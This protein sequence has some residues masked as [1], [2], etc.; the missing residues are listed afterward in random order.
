MKKISLPALII[1][2]LIF[3][4]IPVVQAQSPQQTL[5]QLISDLQK[6]PNNNDLREK[7]I[8]HVQTM[9]PAPAITE[10]AHQ[11]FVIAQTFQKKAKNAKGYE[12]AINEY[13][14]ALLIAP[15]WSEAY[16]NMGITLEQVGRYD[17]AISALKLYIATNPPDAR[18]AQDKIYEIEATKKLA[19]EDRAAEEAKEQ[20][21]RDAER[22]KQELYGWI[23]GSW[24][25]EVIFP[26]NKFQMRKECSREGNIIECKGGGYGTLRAKISDAG[27]QQWQF[28]SLQGW[29]DTS[30]SISADRRQ[31]TFPYNDATC[32][33]TKE[34]W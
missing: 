8:K 3:A 17:E 16:N 7:I 9:K 25:W 10:E 11:H 30:V 21:K 28:E 22:R 15:W 18:T 19:Q 33:M 34:G 26:S 13:R 24:N 14:Q 29:I 4:L 27:L 5:N 31:I 23:I 6:N 12:L 20:A 32:R 1:F 2:V